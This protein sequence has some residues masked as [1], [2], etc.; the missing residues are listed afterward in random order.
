[1]SRIIFIACKIRYKTPCS[2][3]FSDYLVIIQTKLKK[4]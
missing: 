1:M 2:Q 3:M 4:N